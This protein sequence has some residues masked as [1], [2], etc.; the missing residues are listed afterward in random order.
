M[1]EHLGVADADVHRAG[2]LLDGARLEKPKL[3]DPSIPFEE[4]GQDF[5]RLVAGRRSVARV[6]ISR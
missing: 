6:P 3:E 4:G 5:R 1:L 2:G